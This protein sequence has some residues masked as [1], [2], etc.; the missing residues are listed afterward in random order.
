MVVCLSNGKLV[1]PNNKKEKKHASHPFPW[2]EGINFFVVISQE[3]RCQHIT[4]QTTLNFVKLKALSECLTFFSPNFFYKRMQ[5]FLG[6]VSGGSKAAKMASSKTF[7]NPLC[8]EQQ[9]G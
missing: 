7:F 6:L 8:R 1:K 4:T 9:K 5:R 2:F 3:E